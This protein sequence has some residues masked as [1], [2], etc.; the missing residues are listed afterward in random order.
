[1]RVV[2][3]AE[4]EARRIFPLVRNDNVMG[5]PVTGLGLTAKAREA[6]PDYS[7]FR[8]QWNLER[9]QNG[10]LMLIGFGQARD[11]SLVIDIVGEQ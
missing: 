10:S 8:R 5:T 11:R 7:L 3:V 4:D 2:I 1:M 9:I 6:S